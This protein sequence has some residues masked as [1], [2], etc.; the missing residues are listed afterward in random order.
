MR[1]LEPRYEGGELFAADVD[2]R[3]EQMRQQQ[4]WSMEASGFT[5]NATASQS[6]YSGG[7][8]GSIDAVAFSGAMPAQLLFGRGELTVVPGSYGGDYTSTSFGVSP[9]GTP[10]VII[11]GHRGAMTRMDEG[12]QRTQEAI[13]GFVQRTQDEGAAA[14]AR[15]DKLSAAMA[16]LSYLPD[17]VFGDG[18]KGVVGLPRLYT[19]NYMLPNLISAAAN[20]LS[21]ARAGYAAFSGMSTQ[22]QSLAVPNDGG[23]A[24]AWWAGCRRWGCFL[25]AGA[26]RP[27]CRSAEQSA[28]RAASRCAQRS[29]SEPARPRPG[30]APGPVVCHLLRVDDRPG[31]AVVPAAADA[32]VANPQEL[33]RAASPGG[34][35]MLHSHDLPS[36]SVLRRHAVTELN[37]VLGL[38]PADSVL[39]R[40]HA[41]WQSVQQKPVPASVQPGPARVAA[42]RPAPAPMAARASAAPVPSVP[43]APVRPPAAGGVFGWLRRALG[44]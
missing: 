19:N 43:A 33:P 9:D 11:T 17:R 6:L 44:F 2:M 37:R 4:P 32:G 36:D 25:L 5:G 30:F 20:P 24:V 15:G 29:F 13:D 1:N 14:Y 39:R 41:Q 21:T 8:L 12:L 28:E 23:D 18:L 22:D 7:S 38:P 35:T 3:R 42:P 40:H 10:Q 26:I 16:A 34:D 27:W 31:G